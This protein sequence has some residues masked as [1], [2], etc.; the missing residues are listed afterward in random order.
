MPVSRSAL[1]LSKDARLLWASES[2][3]CFCLFFF[4]LAGVL[5]QTSAL[6]A[7]RAAAYALTFGVT[8]F[9]VGIYRTEVRRD[10]GTLLMR[11]VIA[12][13]LSLPAVYVT[14]LLLP[15]DPAGVRFGATNLW[16]HW[17]AEFLLVQLLVIVA[18]RVVFGMALGAPLFSRRVLVV[19][20]SPATAWIRAAG[21]AY[22]IR[23]L[24]GEV[25]RA[26]LGRLW[27]VVVDAATAADLPAD[28]A[29]RCRWN[30]VRVMRDSEFL[31]RCLRRVDV[32]GDTAGGSSPIAPA[33]DRWTRGFDVIGA[34]LLLLAVLPVMGLAALAIA[35]EDGGPVFYRQARVGLHGRE[36]TLMK[37][38]SMRLDAEASGPVWAQQRDP[39]VT[40]TGAFIRRIRIDELPQLV[41]ILRGD[42]SIVGPRPERPHFVAQLAAAIPLYAER[43]RVKP[44]LTGWAQVNYPYGASIEDARA[45]LSYDLYYVKHRSAWLNA[46]T[47]ISTL[48][49][50]LFQ[51]GSR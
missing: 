32:S 22:E 37:F 43:A 4:L 12:A 7:N 23:D 45:K 25:A 26:P 51:E 30:R 34:A 24:R 33:P 41:N 3:L 5:E 27:A 20:T 18:V 6:A 19:G 39:R 42:M 13:V 44:G 14:G 10:L 46:L 29:P 28:L 31:E 47:L 40:R 16:A 8:A 17:A 1:R 35:L 49:V 36:F 50:V 21:D 15:I 11:A 48:R 9:S 38:R 2:V